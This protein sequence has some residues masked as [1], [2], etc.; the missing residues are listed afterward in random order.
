GPRAYRSDRVRQF[1]PRRRRRR[2]TRD[3][4]AMGKRRHHL[5]SESA[6]VLR[7]RSV[8]VGENDG[9]ISEIG[10][11]VEYVINAGPS[12][13]VIDQS[14]S[15]CLPHEE[16]VSERLACGGSTRFDTSCQQLLR[17]ARA[18]QRV[19]EQRVREVHEIGRSRV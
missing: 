11:E 17:R 12:T 7:R 14:S 19:S 15:T 3:L 18:Q 13:A 6:Y 10:I 2:L 16:A 1:I 5:S 8:S 4:A 9:D